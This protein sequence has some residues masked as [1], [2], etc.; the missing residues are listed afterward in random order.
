MDFVK[1]IK[2]RAVE[3]PLTEKTNVNGL[4]THNLYSYLR[5]TSGDLFDEA[6]GHTREIPWNFS[7][8][9]INTRKMDIVKGGG[10]TAVRYYK[11]TIQPND[12]IPDINAILEGK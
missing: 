3:F 6:S 1:A 7:K 12:I 11:S 8:F 4:Y 10:G 2:P 9:L 5:Q